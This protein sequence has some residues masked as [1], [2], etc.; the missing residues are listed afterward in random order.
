MKASLLGL[1]MAAALIAAP[2]MAADMPMAAPTAPVPVWNWTGFYVGVNAGY[3]QND[4]TGDRTCVN[5]AGIVFGA[6]CTLNIQGHVVKPGGAL[7]GG[8][9]GYN[10][11]SGKVVFGIETDLQWSDIKASASVLIRPATP[12]CCYNAADNLNWFGTTRG[13]IGFLATPQLLAYA[14][15]GVIYGNE[16]V[17]ARTSFPVSGFNYPA[18]GSST[19]TGGVVGAGLE[20]AF[21]NSISAK[22]E[23]L[24]YDMG[25]LNVSFLCPAGATT[26]TPGYR[27]SGV[28]AERG[29]L[30]RGGL[31][32]HFNLAGPVVARY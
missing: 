24:Y 8:T 14:T 29:F 32:W 26:C 25:V 20:Y 31:N 16:S 23:G 21:T 19:R 12:V 5:P 4:P 15:G 10:V 3:G 9:A 6:G 11:Q 18:T 13:R 28:F 17:V 1:A 27:E 2:A 7:A 30:V 22:V